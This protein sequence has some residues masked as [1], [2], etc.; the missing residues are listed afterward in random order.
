MDNQRTARELFKVAK[1][2]V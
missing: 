2:L 1:D